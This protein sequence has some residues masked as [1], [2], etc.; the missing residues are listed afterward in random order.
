[1]SAP[2]PPPAA[3]APRASDAASAPLRAAPRPEEQVRTQPVERRQFDEP[4]APR[5]LDAW[6]RQIA[7]LRAAGR[8]AEADEE[9]ARLRRAYTDAV[10]PP[11]LQS[12]AAR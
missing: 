5:P 4:A 3:P 2:P 11:A 7:A 8:D 12:P 1:M 10:I 9:L 6:L